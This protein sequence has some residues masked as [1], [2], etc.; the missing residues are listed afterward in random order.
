M[1]RVVLPGAAPRPREHQHRK[2]LRLLPFVPAVALLATFFLGPIGWTAYISMTDMA[3]T[4][5]RAINYH[6]VWFHNFVKAVE[7]VRVHAAALRTVVFVVVCVIG[8]NG[9][10]MVLAMLQQNR[11]KIMR[12]VVSVV[13][14]GAWVI[15]EIV[16][17]FIWYSFLQPS[18]GTLNR[19]LGSVGIPGQS[20]LMTSPLL[21]V[22][23]ANIWRGCA[24]SMLIYSAALQDIP[25][26]IVEAAEV[27]GANGFQR[28]VRITLPMIKQIVATN[29]VLVTLWTMGVFGLIFAM[30]AGGP[31]SRSETLPILMYDQ[32]FRFGE[33]GY[34]T[35][36]SLLL[37]VIGAVFSVLYLTLLRPGRK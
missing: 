20:W 14:V 35:A 13:V 8:Q 11:N 6:F 25:Q 7:D 33:I 31:A 32:A 10:G 28:F 12:T 26:E 16:S 17:A 27:D 15:P 4:G 30:T 29:L 22:I 34:G 36:V 19:L 21:A 5:A 9:M 24:F 1:T 3:L 2:W 18:G 37:L 23:L